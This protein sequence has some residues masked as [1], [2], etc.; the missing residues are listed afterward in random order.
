VVEAVTRA[1]RAA[2]PESSAVEEACSA[3]AENSRN[4][5]TERSFM[6]EN[7]NG[8]DLRARCWII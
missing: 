4:N 2:S 5:G 8:R 6:G 3:H 7:E 1:M